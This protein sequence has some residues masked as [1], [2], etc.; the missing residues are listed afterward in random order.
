M[1][2][3]VNTAVCIREDGWS[4]CYEAVPRKLEQQE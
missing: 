3:G 1:E 4:V 2:R